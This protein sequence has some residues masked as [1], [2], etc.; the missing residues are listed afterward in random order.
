VF[1]GAHF[2]VRRNRSLIF[3]IPRRLQSPRNLLFGLFQRPAKRHSGGIARLLGVS[4]KNITPVRKRIL[5]S[6][7]DP[8]GTSWLTAAATRPCRWVAIGMNMEDKC[9]WGVDI[10]LQHSR[11]AKWI[12]RIRDFASFQPNIDV[13]LR[14]VGIGGAPIVY[15]KVG[16]IGTRAILR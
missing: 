6:N 5:P 15:L 13:H 2:Q 1:E 10:S 8:G 9:R 11:G 4:F 16:L 7:S 3:V 12:R 14:V